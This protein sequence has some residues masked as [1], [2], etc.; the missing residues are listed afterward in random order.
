MK[1]TFTLLIFAVLAV[2]TV[3]AGG[4]RTYFFKCKISTLDTTL[5]DYFGGPYEHLQDSTLKAFKENEEFFETKIL[6]DLS[7]GNYDSV[8]IHDFVYVH[9]FDKTIDYGYALFLSN[10]KTM[11]SVDKIT[12][13]DLIEIISFRDLPNTVIS[14]INESDT[15]WMKL[16]V[17]DFVDDKEVDECC[18][19]RYLMYDNR[20]D[21]R[22]QVIKEIVEEKKLS[23]KE[24]LI[25]N[26]SKYRI[27]AL[28]ICHCG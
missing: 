7:N 11:V 20:V 22:N 8:K 15:V 2:S 18:P 19:Y 4:Q 14:N 24:K 25:D 13:L 10:E 28:R 23:K 27:V 12:N 3:Y 21:Y 9:L 26:L 17:S 16:P 1:S 5:V 6:F